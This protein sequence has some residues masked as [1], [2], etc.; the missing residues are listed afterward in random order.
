[1]RF[2]EFEGEWK[3]STLGD[4]SVISSGGTP[5]R[6]NLEYWNGEI[7]W[8]TTS[9]IDFNTINHSEETITEEGLRSSSAKICPKGSL[10]MAMYGQGKT[11]GK[12]AV[13]GVDASINQACASI[14]PDEMILN[15]LF[16]FQNLSSRYLD[17]RNLSNQGGQ[18]NLSG[19]IIKNIDVSYPSLC[20]QKELAS[21]FTILDQRIE[22]QSQIIK[23]L[24]TLMKGLRHCIYLRDVFHKA[25]QEVM[26][27]D[28]LN[29]YSKKNTANNLAPVAVGKF[30]IRKREDIYSKDLSNDYSKNKV[31]MKDTLTIG[32][33]STQI[34]FG[35]LCEDERY[36][37]SPAYTTYKIRSVSSKYLEQF[38]IC[39]NSLLSK[40]YMIVGARQG[41]S[42]DK[43]ELLNHRIAIH[44]QREQTKISELF[45]RVESRLET[46]RRLLKAYTDQKKYLLA[47]MFI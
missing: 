16:L 9:L 43:S 5:S 23:E 7:P 28:L 13:L 30:G 25:S 11:R 6:S 40:K 17:I 37:V 27:G 18:E 36:C 47:N 29:E 22:T 2:P 24:E 33:G 44:S 46:E 38:L 8:I 15:V 3:S 14:Q 35:V 1:L 12:V 4:V 42:V 34:D 10:L 19:T 26:L 32:M 20:E 21:F 45:C 31:I 41:K 39:I